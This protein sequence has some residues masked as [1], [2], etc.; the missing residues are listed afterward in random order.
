MVGD[1]M[2]WLVIWA[3]SNTRLSQA[4]R[5]FIQSSHSYTFNHT[6]QV[7]SLANTRVTSNHTK[8][9]FLT[10]NSFRCPIR[11]KLDFES[12]PRKPPWQDLRTDF[13]E[14]DAH[15]GYD[16]SMPYMFGICVFENSSY[17]RVLQQDFWLMQMDF[18]LDLELSIGNYLRIFVG[19]VLSQWEGLSF[20][21]D[22]F[23]QAD[24]AIKQCCFLSYGKG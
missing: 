19:E 11:Y 1:R 13:F 8:Q 18:C 15:H 14:F 16:K 5:R 9:S 12:K 3:V 21:L 20:S 6:R 23:I 24:T 7:V 2:I 22:P 17:C 10:N 4:H